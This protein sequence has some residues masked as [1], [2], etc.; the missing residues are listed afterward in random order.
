MNIW[1]VM[2]SAGLI[3]YGMRLFFILA[4]SEKSL[5]KNVRIGLE[6]VP[7]AV[8]TAIIVPEVLFS[9]GSLDISFDNLR[10]AA[11]FLAVI[12]AWKTKSS[13][14]TVITGMLILWVLQVIFS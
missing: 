14:F 12:V 4:I 7:P 3:T 5:P 13:I 1:L 9:D 2:V 6:F 11:A 8:L 10:L